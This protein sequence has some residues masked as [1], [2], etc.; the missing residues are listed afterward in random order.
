MKV[1]YEGLLKILCR[2]YKGVYTKERIAE[3]IEYYGASHLDENIK[4]IGFGVWEVRI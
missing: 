2:K 3:I 1:Q 4:Y